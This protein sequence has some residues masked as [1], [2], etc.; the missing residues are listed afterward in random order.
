MLEIDV[1]MMIWG[2]LISATMKATVHLEQNYQDHLRV[3]ENT[4]FDKIKHLFDISRKLIRIKI[5][6]CM[7]HLRLT[8]IQF[9]GLEVL[10]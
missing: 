8:G 10:C 9:H 2:I 4:D 1:N 3:T 7:E 6:K 5:E